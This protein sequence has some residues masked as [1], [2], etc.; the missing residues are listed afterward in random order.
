M[1][2]TKGGKFGQQQPAP[3]GPEAAGPD[4]WPFD[5]AGGKPAANP[6]GM[7]RKVLDQAN[8]APGAKGNAGPEATGKAGQGKG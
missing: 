4:E 2:G 5:P 8:P 6:E 7:A 1:G 3:Q